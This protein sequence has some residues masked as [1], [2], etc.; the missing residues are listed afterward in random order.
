MSYIGK[1]EV[2]ARGILCSLNDC[3]ISFISVTL[4]IGGPEDKVNIV[5]PFKK[6]LDSRKVKVMCRK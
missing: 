3:L 2:G 1:D 6:P 5:V 4:R